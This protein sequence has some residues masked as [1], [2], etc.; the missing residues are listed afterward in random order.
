VHLIAEQPVVAS[1]VLDA[2]RVD[3]LHLKPQLC[4]ESWRGRDREPADLNFWMRDSASHAGH[5][6]MLD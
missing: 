5:L 6:P 3:G 1:T 2:C 4:H